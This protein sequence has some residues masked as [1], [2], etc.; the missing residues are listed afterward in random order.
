[1]TDATLVFL[2]A[3][4]II[5]IGAAGNYLFR[6]TGIPDM[7]FLLALGLLVGPLLG[8]IKAQDIEPLTPLL[9]ILAVVIILFDGGLGLDIQKAVGQAP[10]AIVL[11]VTGFI[12]TTAAVALFSK[13][14]LGWRLLQGILL[15]SMLGGSSSVVV[16]A[17]VNRLG[18][19]EKGT[20]TLILESSTTDILCIVAAIAVME[21][22]TTGL[23]PV[24]ALARE[25]TS[26]FTTGIVLG[27]LVGFF[28]LNVLPKLSQETYKYMVTLSLIFLTYIASES[29]GGSGAISALVFGLILANSQGILTML[30]RPRIEV[31]DDSFRTLEAEIVFLVKAFFFVYLGLIVAFPHLN[32]IIIALGISVILLAVRY[33]AVAISTVG[34]DLWHEKSGMTVLYGRGLAA[35]ILAVLPVQYG[36]PNAETYTSITLLAIVFTAII[37]AV[38]AT[39]FKG[40][41]SK[42]PTM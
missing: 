9:S 24:Q 38:G 19:S 28:W 29:L 5:L 12:L 31:A 18:F 23:P 35:A 25:M 33:V 17:L 11:A 10:R 42:N 16:I 39:R 22:M 6:K 20:T 27:A 30:R 8:I 32:L 2:V 26:R 13:Y 3:A 21:I 41:K 40:S 34:S 37:T 1:M 15:G 4:T 7:L 36:L 14:F